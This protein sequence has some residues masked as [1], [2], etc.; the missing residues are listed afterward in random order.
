MSQGRCPLLEPSPPR[1]LVCRRPG[2]CP[3]AQPPA[4][5][6][7]HG[8]GQGTLASQAAADTGSASGNTPQLQSCPGGQGRPGPQ[9]RARVA[10]APTPA[11]PGALGTRTS[12]GP[13]RLAVPALLPATLAATSMASGGRR[14][15]RFSSYDVTKNSKTSS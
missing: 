5:P 2:Q 8:P 14:D 12:Q 4:R 6:P 13:G 1:C 7:L 10:V 15:G 3:W 9:H 11:A